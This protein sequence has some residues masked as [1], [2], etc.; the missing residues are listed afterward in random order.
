MRLAHRVLSIFPPPV[1]LATGTAGVDISE[2]SVKCTVLERH[3][4]ASHL[5]SYSE[6]PLPLGAI[7]GGDIQLP[8]KITETLRSVRLR[9]G[10]RYANACLP[11]RKGYLYQAIVPGA[12]RELR[13]AIEF[14]LETHVPVP[15]KDVAFDFEVVRVVEGGTA[16]SVTA[17]PKHIVDA[18]ARVFHDAG[19]VLRSLEAEPQS[20]A[21]AVLSKKDRSGAVMVV[22]FGATATRIIIAEYGVVVFSA[23]V[24]VG[25]DALTTSVAKFFNISVPEAENMK[26][27]RGF[28][29]NSK[30]TDLV[31]AMFTT[32]SVIRDEVMQNISYWNSLSSD[33]LPRQKI[34]KIILSGGGANLLGFPEYLEGATG[35]PVALAD[36]WAN[37]CSLDTY[38]PPVSFSKS[39][40]YAAALGLAERGGAH[41]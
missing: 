8:E 11:E 23:T 33:A 10:V 36:V 3:G 22:D 17:Y 25:G 29:I 26:S 28:L 16:V 40:E 13:S 12:A 34:Q 30:N 9:Q 24:D 4:G 38:V 5:A 20:T 37:A 14:D 7:V 15:P 2:G 41:V 19:I 21:R 32:V 39:L 31:E 1:F 18:Y 27:E 6:T 35:I